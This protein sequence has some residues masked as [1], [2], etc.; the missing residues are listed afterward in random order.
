MILIASHSSEATTVQP[1]VEILLGHGENVLVYKADLVAA[2]KIHVSLALDREGRSM[3]TYDNQ[4]F[5]PEDIE[6]AWYRRPN[7]FG[8]EPLNEVFLIYLDRQRKE[9][10]DSLWYSIP[11]D[12]WL[13]DPAILESQYGDKL[14]QLRLAQ[15]SGFITP[16][17]VISNDWGKAYDS[18]G[19]SEVLMKLPNGRLYVEQ[20]PHMLMSTIIDRSK[21]SQIK[22]TI[23]FPGI[24]QEFISKKREWR[25]TV[26]GEKVFP[27]AIYT[28]RKARA[29]WRKHQRDKRTVRFK[30]EQLPAEVQQKCVSMLHRIGVRF[31]AFDL[32]ESEDGTFTF[33]EVNLNGQYQ[34]LVSQLG[35]P[36]P[37]AIAVELIDIKNRKVGTTV[38]SDE[39]ASI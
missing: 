24:W 16:R 34:W 20:E 22:K 7:I 33:L 10:Q 14:V 38:V 23:P 30:A 11:K 5:S 6:A 3:F 19:A 25:V 28:S 32:I 36:I 18:F 13:N 17:T 31:G 9:C 15:E 21:Y 29:D 1:V 37:E 27:V 12:R 39:N 35:L 8:P 4:E 2:G 26:V